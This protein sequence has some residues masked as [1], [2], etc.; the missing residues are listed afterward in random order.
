MVNGAD[1]PVML[2]DSALQRTLDRGAKDSD[3]ERGT[4][5]GYHNGPVW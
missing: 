4:L 3:G 5:S 2:I 1:L